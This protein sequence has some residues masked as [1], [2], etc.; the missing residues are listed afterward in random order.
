MTTREILIIACIPG[1]SIGGLTASLAGSDLLNDVRG[2]LPGDKEFYILMLKHFLPWDR[3]RIWRRII[4]EHRQLRPNSLLVPVFMVGLTL[5]FSSLLGLL[6]VF[7][8]SG[9]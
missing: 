9:L 5:A 3:F 4:R 6:M 1:V 8:I 7:F 2:L